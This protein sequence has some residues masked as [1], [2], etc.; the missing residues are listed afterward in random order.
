MSDLDDFGRALKEA[1]EAVVDRGPVMSLLVDEVN[2]SVELFLDTSKRTYGDWIKGEGADI[3]L[4]RDAET[5]KVV[6]CYLPLYQK[7]LIVDRL[8]KE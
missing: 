3:C 1:S 8:V 6:G 7:E 5:H 2:S 4:Y